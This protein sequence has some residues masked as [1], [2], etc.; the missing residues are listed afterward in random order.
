MTYGGFLSPDRRVSSYVATVGNML[1]VTNSLIQ[2][3]HIIE[4][5]AGQR[6]A[7]AAAPEYLFFRDRY[8]RDEPRES[9]LIVLTDAAIRRWCSPRWRIGDS[10][11][12]RAAAIMT[13]A[14]ARHLNYLAFNKINALPLPVED[15][16][17]GAGELRL[18]A[19]GATSSAYGSLEF[20]TPINE[21][22]LTKVTQ[23]EA[24]S[25]K[26]WRDSYQQNWRNYFDPIAVRLSSS[27]NTLA[28][29]LT[30]MPLIA[31]TEYREFIAISEGSKL[32]PTS[33]DP[34]NA[35]FHVALAIN[36]NSERMRSLGRE[37]SQFIPQLKIEPF[38]WVGKSVAVYVDDDPIWEEAAQAKKPDEFFRDHLGELPIAAYIESSNSL[39]MALFLTALHGFIDVSAPG[40]IVWENK[41]HL[42]QTYVKLS[43]TPCCP[44]TGWRWRGGT[45]D[46]L[47]HCRRRTRD[48]TE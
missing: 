21:M 2:L 13:E 14:Q 35:A 10:R 45:G 30:V 12:T 5:Q 46:L 34:H 39:K 28:A 22:E 31:S 9:G 44:R 16:L 24:D 41:T 42:D 38:S 18:T 17:V 3:Q 40:L 4:T 36:P 19:A 11:R 48:H 1:V 8:H 23:V 37:I 6:P 27:N 43:A 26:R 33:G 29:D 20:M 7:M 25:Y 15:D 32:L 47:Q